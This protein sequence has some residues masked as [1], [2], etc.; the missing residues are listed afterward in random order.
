MDMSAAHSLM[1]M[2]QTINQ[3]SRK[4]RAGEPG[5]EDYLRAVSADPVTEWFT[6]LLQEK[7]QELQTERERADRLANALR[8]WRRE[9]D[10][11]QPNRQ[12]SDAELRLLKV[13]RGMGIIE[14]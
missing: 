1:E 12:E 13:L 9:V 10:E 6:G 8:A 2:V 11:G 14:R 3:M 4:A 7:N 5:I